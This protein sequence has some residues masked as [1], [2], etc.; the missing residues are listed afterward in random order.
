MEYGKRLWKGLLLGSVLALSL[1]AARAE[2]PVATGTNG[3]RIDLYD[4]QGTI[5][6]EGMKRAVYS[7]LA[8]HAL[9][10]QTVE[11][12]WR[13]DNVRVLLA[14]VDGDRAVVDVGI[15]TWRRSDTGQRRL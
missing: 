4:E 14:F 13:A 3:D 5:C 1:S 12:C 10:G 7:Y 15:F 8:P 9:A 11:G 2:E 6:L